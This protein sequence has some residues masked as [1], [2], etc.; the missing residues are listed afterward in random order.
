LFKRQKNIIYKN[1]HYI[2]CDI[3]RINNIFIYY[4]NYNIVFYFILFNIII[5]SLSFFIAYQV[6]EY[7]LREQSKEPEGF[8]HWFNQGKIT[9]KGLFVSLIFGIVFGFLD[10]FFL[11][12]GIDSMMEFI[13][14]GTL[15]KG[16]WG[17][18]Y[19]DFMGATLGAAIASIGGNLIDT[20][21]TPPIWINAIAMPIGC[22][23][24][25]KVGKFIT[26]KD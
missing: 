12:M 19:S 17:N 10:N 23:I 14:G 9:L 22:I 18:T 2:S 4:M 3:K 25:M 6:K 20:D 1:P 5:I 16:A 7:K 13:P 26:K 24:G 11:W 15:T 8:I 21:E